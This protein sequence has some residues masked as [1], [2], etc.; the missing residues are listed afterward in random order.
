MAIKRSYGE[1]TFSWKTWIQEHNPFQ[2]ERQAKKWTNKVLNYSRRGAKLKR[3]Q[4]KFGDF[5]FLHKDANWTSIYD[6]TES[7][8][9]KF[10]EQAEEQFEMLATEE[11]VAKLNDAVGGIQAAGINFVTVD[12]MD[13]A[14]FIEEAEEEKVDSAVETD[15]G[16]DQDVANAEILQSGNN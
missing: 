11:V 14:G 10:L 9:N 13:L 5:L 16:P 7:D 15:D 2:D 12:Y 1:L 3:I 6:L 8:L 4:E